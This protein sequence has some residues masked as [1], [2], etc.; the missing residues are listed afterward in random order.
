MCF[1]FKQG[2]CWNTL[3]SRPYILLL[4]RYVQSDERIKAKKR[5]HSRL[6]DVSFA[7]RRNLFFNEYTCNPSLVFSNGL[8]PEQIF[9]DNVTCDS[10]KATTHYFQHPPSIDSFVLC[11]LVPGKN[12]I[13]YKLLGT[14]NIRDQ[15]F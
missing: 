6:F 10:S 14:N 2:T 7:Q 4:C 3:L 13:I 8:A 15:R 5:K 12:V 11:K 1:F 9:Y